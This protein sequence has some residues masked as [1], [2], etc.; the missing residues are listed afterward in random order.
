MSS[1]TTLS[2]NSS[3][4]AYISDLSSRSNINFDINK[5]DKYNSKEIELCTVLNNRYCN[6]NQNKRSSNKMVKNIRMVKDA[7]DYLH[8]KRQPC[9]NM[10]FSPM[11]T[12]GSALRF[13]SNNIYIKKVQESDILNL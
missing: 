2:L 1:N 4:G 6:Y 11:S 7:S 12:N 8:R 13:I 10:M 9:T 3:Q 5:F